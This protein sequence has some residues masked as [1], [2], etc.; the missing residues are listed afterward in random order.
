MRAVGTTLLAALLGSACALPGTAAEMFDIGRSGTGQLIEGAAAAAARADA[1]TVLL[2]GGLDGAD[3]TVVAV[4]EA[5]AAFERPRAA[6]RIRVLA[7]PL[8]N[9][10]GALLEFPP[11]GAAYRE[12]S[13]SHAL[14]RWI[15]TQAPD[16]VLIAGSD[17]FGLGAALAANAPAGVGLVPS[18]GWSG[19]SLD[20]LRA[21]DIET[22]AAHREIERRLARSPLQHPRRKE[23]SP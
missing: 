19:E 21:G 22:S 4:R 6:R 14:W 7:V 20:A 23:P 2:I 3:A 1:P 16:L 12:R 9:P 15:G 18:R 5:L 11:S 13:E 10:D 8:A 17:R